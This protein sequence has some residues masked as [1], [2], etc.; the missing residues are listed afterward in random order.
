MAKTIKEPTAATQYVRDCLLR[1]RD[2][3]RDKLRDETQN[4]RARFS[5]GLAAEII[6]IH[7][8]RSAATVKIWA[9]ID[10]RDIPV[11]EFKKL[12]DYMRTHYGQAASS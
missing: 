10:K 5:Y 9:S 11:A 12:K 3:H 4:P 6:G 2:Y 1:I 8:G 7:L